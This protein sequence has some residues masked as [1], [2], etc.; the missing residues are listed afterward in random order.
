MNNN[1][2]Q[3]F[4]KN[5]IA[6]SILGLEEPSKQLDFFPRINEAS[7]SSNNSNL[8]IVHSEAKPNGEEVHL[9]RPSS[10]VALSTNEIVNRLVSQY[11]YKTQ[12]VKAEK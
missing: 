12:G 7:A 9:V 8:R 1:F 10:D 2:Q 5:C 11:S 3:N 4:S 6:S